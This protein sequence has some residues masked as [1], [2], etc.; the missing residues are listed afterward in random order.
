MAEASKTKVLLPDE[1]E[2]KAGPI[3]DEVPVLPTRGTVIYPYLVVPLFV[4]RPRSVHALETAMA[5]DH[6]IVLVAQRNTDVDDPSP[7]DLFAVGTLGEVVQMLRLPDGT[8]RVMI[9]GSERVSLRSFLHIDPYMKAHVEVLSEVEQPGIE[10]EA[11]MR[12]VIG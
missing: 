4:G 11:L 10:T 7:D 1:V 3:P 8:I 2:A 6:R 9:E 12:T 5:E